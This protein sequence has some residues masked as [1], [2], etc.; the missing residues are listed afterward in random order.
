MRSSEAIVALRACIDAMSQDHPGDDSYWAAVQQAEAVVAKADAAP[1]AMIDVDRASESIASMVADWYGNAPLPNARITAN[2]IARRLA[3][4][5][6]A[7]PSCRQ[8]V[9]MD[10]SK[11]S[12]ADFLHVAQL[13]RDTDEKVVRASLSN[14]LNVIIAALEIAENAASCDHVGDPICTKCASQQEG[15]VP[16]ECTCR[17]AS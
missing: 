4:F 5:A 15:R 11:F 12:A 7:D 3:R 17:G 2:V 14:W 8:F 1:P 13:L 6:L 10:E 9:N 16:T